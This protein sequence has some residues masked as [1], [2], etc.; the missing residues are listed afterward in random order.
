MILN[1]NIYNIEK[2]KSQIQE[3]A[4]CCDNPSKGVYR[5]GFVE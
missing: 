5:R 2:Y 3:Y 4:L 1:Q